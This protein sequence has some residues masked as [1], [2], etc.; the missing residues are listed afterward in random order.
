MSSSERDD[1]AASCEVV[2]V[3]Q[4]S[5]AAPTSIVVSTLNTTVEVT[6]SGHK[7]SIQKG[8]PTQ[9]RL[10]WMPITTAKLVKNGTTDPNNWMNI[11]LVRQLLSDKPFECDRL[12]RGSAWNTSLK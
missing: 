6:L 2:H 7:N 12:K 4:R 5:V 10:R 8:G 3:E 9:Q 1:E 11:M